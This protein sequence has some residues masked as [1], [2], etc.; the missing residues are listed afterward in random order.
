MR[1]WFIVLVLAAFAVA[2]SL[3]IFPSSS[4]AFSDSLPFGFD[5]SCPKNVQVLKR[6][7]VSVHALRNGQAYCGPDVAL[8]GFDK[9]GKNLDVVPLDCTNGVSLFGVTVSG[10]GVYSAN[11]TFD[12]HVDYCLFAVAGTPPQSTPEFW[13][14]V[15]LFAVLLA[16]LLARNK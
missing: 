12:G 5:V 9:K 15:L 1:Y 4:L 11:A 2:G 14:P 10:D 13:P 7:N 6:V 16:G 8:S 3:D